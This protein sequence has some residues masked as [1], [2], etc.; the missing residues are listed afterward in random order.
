MVA[1]NYTIG[2]VRRTLMLG[3]IEL[4]TREIVSGSA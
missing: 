2:L 4:T 3:V 1:A